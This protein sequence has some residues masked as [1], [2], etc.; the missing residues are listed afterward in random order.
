MDYKSIRTMV[1][2]GIGTII[3]DRA[4]LNWLNIAMMEEIND[5]LTAFKKQQVKLLVFKAEG[6]AFSVG[7][8][9]AEHMG[10]LAEKMIDVFHGIFRKMDDL[11][12]PSIA[13]VDGAA[14]G[15]GCEVAIYCDMVVASER[16]KFGQ[17]EIQVG[18]F[19]PIAALIMP[20]IMGRKKA[21][22]LILGG[23][24]IGAKD[25]QE[26]GLVNA[27][28]PVDT[29]AEDVEKFIKKF[30]GLS[31][32]VMKSTRKACLEGLGDDLGKGLQNIENIYLKELMATND[33]MEGLHAFLDK[34]KPVW[35]E[36]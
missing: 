11:G 31:G 16:A 28:Y 35:K 6:K 18:V 23:E 8:E 3:L 13:V 27:V 21:M 22:E 26:L 17:P 24:T 36:K 20:R 25:A 32:V 30:K 29:F 10:G 14:L 33:A 7:V 12:V 1:E 9:V 2:E 19:P 4:P 34:R 5:A 15:G